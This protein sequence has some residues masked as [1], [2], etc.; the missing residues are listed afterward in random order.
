M[1]LELGGKSPALVDRDADLALVA[2][3]LVAGKLLNAGQT[4]I[5]PDYA[6]VPAER[7]DAFV[8]AI[9]SAAKRLYPSFANNP[10]YTSIINERH[11]QRLTGL[12]DDARAKGCHVLLAPTVNIHRS[13]LAGRNFECYSEDPLLSGRIAAGFVQSGDDPSYY[14]SR[15]IRFENNGYTMCHPAGANPAHWA[16]ARINGNPYISKSDWLKAG[17]DES[18]SFSTTRARRACSQPTSRRPAA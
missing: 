2:P 5:A 16:W 8:D 10:D 4:C 13:P 15:N 14:T 11:L 9:S 12:L 3:R 18:G 6:L 1:T 17:N 7:L